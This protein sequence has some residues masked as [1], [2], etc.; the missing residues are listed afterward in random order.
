M[1][2]TARTL[3]TPTPDIERTGD[4]QQLAF[5]PVP[6]PK[7]RPTGAQLREA[8]TA[9]HVHGTAC[10]LAFEL[11]SY[12]QPGGMVFP[13]VRTLAVGLGVEPRTVR[14]H[15][16]RL[17]RIGL[18]V[19][20]CRKGRTNLYELRLPGPVA[21]ETDGREAAIASAE[22]RIAEAGPRIVGS[23]PPGSYDPPEVIR[24]VTRKQRGAAR[25][26]C[27]DC[28]YSWPAAYGPDCF[29]CLRERRSRKRSRAEERNAY[30]R[31]YGRR[32]PGDEEAPRCAR[33]EPPPMTPAQRA[34]KEAELIAAG[35]RTRDGQWTRF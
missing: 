15:L 29:E 30:F 2:S 6:A 17:E 16:A 18:W 10:A 4:A 24:E 32:M 22:P 3:A 31:A 8:M 9:L 28:G 1:K 34:E 5:G 13:S 20:V 12:W 25:A 27:S 33:P 7:P 23:A 21:T 35:W 19:R 11:L 14:T 26:R